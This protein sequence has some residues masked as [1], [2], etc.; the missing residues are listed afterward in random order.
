MQTREQILSQLVP[1]TRM[2]PSEVF[3]GELKLQELP[4]AAFRQASRAAAL[5]GNRIDVD[6]WNGGL[7]CAGVVDAD[8]APL[9]TLDELLSWPHRAAVWNEIGRIAELLL[10][11]SEVGREALTKSDPETDPGAGP[12]PD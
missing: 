4:R 6:K 5:D 1:I 9:F 12:G 8:G 11:I 2:E 10:N 7:F 3:G